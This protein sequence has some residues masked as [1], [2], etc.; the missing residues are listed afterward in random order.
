MH[1]GSDRRKDEKRAEEDHEKNNI[2]V[3]I[4]VFSNFGAAK[5]KACLPLLKAACDSF[6]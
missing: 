4:R 6:T 2:L 1:K 3:L 5:N